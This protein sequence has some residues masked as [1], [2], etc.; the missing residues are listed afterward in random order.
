MKK[1]FFILITIFV[2]SNNLVFAGENTVGESSGTDC[3]AISQGSDVQGDSD[4]GSGSDSSVVG[5]SVLSE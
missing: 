1:I 2:L 4:S 5:S 3:S